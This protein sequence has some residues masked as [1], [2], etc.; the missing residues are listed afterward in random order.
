M[1]VPNSMRFAPPLPFRLNM[2]MKVMIVNGSATASAVL[3]LEGW[4]RASGQPQ[5]LIAF[6]EAVYR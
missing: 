2:V 6:K 3:F 4:T 1:T 5:G